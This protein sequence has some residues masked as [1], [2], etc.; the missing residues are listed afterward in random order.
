MKKRLNPER[1]F[2]ALK[3][4][5]DQGVEIFIAV[6]PSHAYRWSINNN[7]YTIASAMKKIEDSIRAE[8]DREMIDWLKIIVPVGILAF[9]LAMAFYIVVMATHNGVN[10]ASAVSHVVP[11]VTKTP[12]PHAVKNPGKLKI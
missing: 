3:P 5:L 4:V 7:A 10:L 8:R 12:A 9:M 6:N 2:Q 1:A 11:H